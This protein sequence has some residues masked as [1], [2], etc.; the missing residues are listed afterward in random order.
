[1]AVEV[2]RR[3]RHG[4]T[5]EHVLA[6]VRALGVLAANDRRAHRVGVDH[7]GYIIEHFRHRRA[8]GLFLVDLLGGLDRYGRGRV[9]QVAFELFAGDDDRLENNALLVG[10]D[11]GLSKGV[12]RCQQC[13]ECQHT[14]AL[15][16]CAV[17]MC[18]QDAPK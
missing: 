15:A 6:I 8:A 9:F 10:S 13:R 1:M 17:W 12:R 5:P 2:D 18:L 4:A 3:P 11:D 14:K 7:V 16:Q